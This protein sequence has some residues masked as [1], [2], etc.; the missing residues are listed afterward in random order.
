[1]LAEEL[2]G[3][4]AEERA[5]G[6]LASWVEKAGRRPAAGGWRSKGW[7]EGRVEKERGLGEKEKRW[8]G[9]ICPLVLSHLALSRDPPKDLPNPMTS[10]PKR[11]WVLRAVVQG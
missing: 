10:G 11:T 1:M 2:E 5:V 3:A 9:R 8:I 4:M 7:E 6:G